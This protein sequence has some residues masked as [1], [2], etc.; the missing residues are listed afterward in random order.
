VSDGFESYNRAT[1]DN[2]SLF[3]KINKLI[4]STEQ[5]RSQGGRGCRAPPSTHAKKDGAPSTCGWC[6]RGEEGRG[7]EEWLQ[8]TANNR[9]KE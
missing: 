5:W 2:D 4:I 3:V 9:R 8:S 6:W 1:G 7:R